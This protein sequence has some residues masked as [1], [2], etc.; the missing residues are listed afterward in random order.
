MILLT[1]MERETLLILF[2]D[3][4]S[5]YNANSI[6]KVLG[7]SHVGAQKIFKRLLKENLI[8]DKQ[9]GK[10]II[11]K[12]R[13]DDDYVCKLIAFLLADEANSKFRRWKEEFKELFKKNR[14]VML[15]GSTIIDYS[16]ARDI[17]MMMIMDKKDYK[18]VKKIIDE[19]QQILPKKIHSIQLTEEALIQN[20]KKR[21]EAIVDIVKNAVILYGED[22]YVRVI[23]NVASS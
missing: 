18:P 20:I 10:S 1:K 9:I 23:K 16:T 14:I 8:N 2:K 17:D 13:L 22:K 21:Q 11:Y 6:S 4:A 5:Y 19:K 12:L 15:F 7:I 3:F